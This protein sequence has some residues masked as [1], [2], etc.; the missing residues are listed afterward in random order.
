MF[1]S[2]FPNNTVSSLVLFAQNPLLEFQSGLTSAG[3]DHPVGPVWW[4]LSSGDLNQGMNK[5]KVRHNAFLVWQ[6]VY[7]ARFGLLS[8]PKTIKGCARFEEK[9]SAWWRRLKTRDCLFSASVLYRW[10]FKKIHSGELYVQAPIV[11][12]ADS[13]IP[14]IYHYLADKYQGDQLCIQ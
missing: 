12:T 11:Q 2:Y 9:H 5:T 6:S 1:V 14:R 4:L 8:T 13:A 3:C 7:C 10:F